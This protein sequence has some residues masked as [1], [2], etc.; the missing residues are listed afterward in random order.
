MTGSIKVWLITVATLI[1]CTVF[2]QKK[3]YPIYIHFQNWVGDKQLSFD[4]AYTSAQ[5]E[6]FTVRNFR[7]YISH[8]SATG[9]NGKIYKLP[10]GNFLVDERKPDSKTIIL[11]VPTSTVKAIAFQV[12]VDSAKNIAG[13]QTGS[14]D[15]ANGMFWAWNSGYIFA[16]LEGASPQSKAPQ[17]GFTYHIGGFRTG[18]NAIRKVELPLSKVLSAANDTVIVK[19]DVNAWFT[20][21]HSFKIADRPSIMTPGL[22]AMQIADNYSRMFSIVPTR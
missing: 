22:Q 8:F 6:T 5:G 11:Q 14:L 19:A 17:N 20:G 9:G 10:E 2:G 4:S 16:K 3:S 12:G 13:V 1:S 21:I 15:P 18:E 7:Y